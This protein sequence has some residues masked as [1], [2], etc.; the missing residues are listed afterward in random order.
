MSNQQLNNLIGQ[1]G[2]LIFV[3]KYGYLNEI[4]G[5]LSKADNGK[6]SFHVHGSVTILIEA[7]RVID[8]EVI[9]LCVT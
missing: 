6:F 7:S 5:K 9:E 3:N 2:K 4:H 8:F 1:S